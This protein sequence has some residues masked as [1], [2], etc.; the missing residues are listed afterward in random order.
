MRIFASERD[1]VHAAHQI[2]PPLICEYI[3]PFDAVA[4]NDTTALGQCWPHRSIM[5]Q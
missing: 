5:R 2:T 3:G 1:E 4:S